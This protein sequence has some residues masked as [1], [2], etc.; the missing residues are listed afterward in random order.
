MLQGLS[1]EASPLSKLNGVQDDVM[2]DIV[3]KKMLIKN[4]VFFPD[5]E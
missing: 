1:D 2:R 3:W 4:W 5:D